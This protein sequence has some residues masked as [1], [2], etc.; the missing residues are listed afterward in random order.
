MDTIVEEKRTMRNRGPTTPSSAW[1]LALS[2]MHVWIV[3]E[4]VGGRESGQERL[5]L[6]SVLRV[7]IT[8]FKIYLITKKILTLR[9]RPGLWLIPPG[10]TWIFFNCFPNK[11]N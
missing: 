1:K 9:C 6:K 10:K 4:A 3:G 8:Y 2:A 11:F 5:L 7:G